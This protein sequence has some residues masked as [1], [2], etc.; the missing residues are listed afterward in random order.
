MKLLESLKIRDANI[1]NRIMMSPMAMYS[2]ENGI[3]ND[4]HLV[5]Y[6]SRAI[7]GTGIIMME[8]T[9]IEKKGKISPKDLV[10]EN[11]KQKNGLSR[12]AE[13]INSTGSI[14][15]I[16]LS[17]A[18]RK[19]RSHVPWERDIKIEKETVNAIAPSSLP[20][21][22]RY[23]TPKELTIENIKKLEKKFAK[24]A[25]M[26]VEAGIKII[27]LHSAH[28]YLLHEFL[29]PVTNKRN[30]IYGG[31]IENRTR[32]LIET[33]DE[34]RGSIPEGNPLFVRISGVDFIENGWSLEDSVYL[35]KELKNHGVDLIDCSS[36]GISP[37]V[38]VPEEKGYNVFISE[39]IKKEVGIL[40][41]VVGYIYQYDFAEKI[42]EENKADMV[43]IG[44]ALL[45]DPYW[46][47]K[48]EIA[49]S[50]KTWPVQYERAFTVKNNLM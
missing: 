30:D 28:G 41:S 32:M 2:A 17:H 3:A 47:M 25:K 23:P 7:G 50:K 20:Y 44:R 14:P 35:A 10:L 21:N 18:G 46:V 39:K 45:R 11:E 9:A 33:V 6:G 29:S 15:G 42:L 34:I 8:A 4:F 26:A 1:R 27:E 19:A 49:E 38:K 37:N 16:Q 24:S 36:G 5:H 40:V 13:F 31:K 22:E 12:I 43:T 48:Q